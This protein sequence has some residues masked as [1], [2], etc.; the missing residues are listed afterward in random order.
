[1]L[2]RPVELFFG[3]DFGH[4]ERKPFELVLQMLEDG[5]VEEVPMPQP[6]RRN[7]LKFRTVYRWKGSRTPVWSAAFERRDLSAQM[8]PCVTELAAEGVSTFVACADAWRGHTTPAFR[9]LRS[10]QAGIRLLIN[11]STAPA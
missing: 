1:M 9:G 4:C 10:I 3:A 2:D 7:P 11:A 5:E 8:P 6:T